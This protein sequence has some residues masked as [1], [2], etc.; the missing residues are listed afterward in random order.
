MEW[1]NLIQGTISTS[2]YKGLEL[3]LAEAPAAKAF[4]FKVYPSEKTQDITAAK[5]LSLSRLP[6]EQVFPA[7]QCKV[8]KQETRLPS[9]TYI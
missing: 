7:S 6:W 5:A 4:Q 1:L 3:E 8:P 2:T 9:R